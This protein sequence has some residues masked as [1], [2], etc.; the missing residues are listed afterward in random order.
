MGESVDGFQAWCMKVTGPNGNCIYFPFQG[1]RNDMDAKYNNG[2]ACYWINS[3]AADKNK[4]LAAFFLSKTVANGKVIYF[5]GN[6]NVW[7]ERFCGFPIRPVM[8]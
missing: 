7:P 8:E 2:V 6:K 4:G 5:I 1:G 3:T